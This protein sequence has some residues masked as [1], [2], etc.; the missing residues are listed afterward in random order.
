MQSATI[1]QVREYIRAS[2]DKSK[3]YIGCDSRNISRGNRR[4]TI[5]VTAIVI[6]LDGHKGAKVFAF[7]EKVPQIRSMRQRL[8]QE[9]YYAIGKYDEL[10][11]AIGNREFSIHLDYHPSEVHKSNQ[12]VKEA[13]GAVKGMGLPYELKPASYAATCAADWLGRHPGFK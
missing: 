10:K 9:V 5:Y 7:E 3:V 12:V 6:H 1:E 11:D 2:S 8:A 13:V 4:Y